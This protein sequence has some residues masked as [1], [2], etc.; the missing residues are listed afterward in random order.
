MSI[1]VKS[2]VL[3]ELIDPEAKVE[4]VAT[5]FTFTE[6]PIWN[7]QGKFLLFSDMP[8][9]VRRRW[10]EADGVREVM[11]PSSKCNGMVYDAHGNLLV[12][13]HVT[14]S[15]ALERPD[16]TRETLATHYR[17]KELNS[18]NDVVTRSDGMIYFSDPSYGRVP[19]FGLE[20]E[21]ELSF[22]G[23]YRVA[24]GGGEPELVVGEDEFEQPNGLCFSPDES[25]M[26]INDS[27]RALIR[28]YDVQADG[29]LTN[30]RLF[31]DGIGRGVIEEGIPDGMKCD[32]RG[33]IWV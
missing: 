27:P 2:Q 5:G 16:G 17:G 11:R 13:E 26:Y 25:L 15:V 14:S 22:Q 18:P 32:E 12:C 9:D 20:R 19:G 6:G 29:N 21:Q 23:V 28:V 33:N 3:E 7:K 24:P 8:G 4:Q 1:Q 31:F 10:S 30:G